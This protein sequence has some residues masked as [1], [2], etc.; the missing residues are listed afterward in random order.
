VG[1][2]QWNFLGSD[3]GVSSSDTETHTAAAAFVAVAGA[4]N[5]SRYTA[6]SPA[7][8]GQLDGFAPGLPGQYAVTQFNAES[9]MKYRGWSLQ[10]ENHWKQVRDTVT[11]ATRGLRGGYIASGYFPH[12]FWK[13][14]PREIELAYRYGVVDPDTAVPRDLRQEHSFAVNVFI[15]G[16]DNKFTFDLSRLSAQG[17]T[18]FA[19]LRYRLQYDIWF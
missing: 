2:Y 4:R 12:N 9:Q 17:S 11:G 7:G 15:E 18:G 3:P 16:H 1:R 6:F 10:N 5:T 13:A 8:G 14:V 19:R